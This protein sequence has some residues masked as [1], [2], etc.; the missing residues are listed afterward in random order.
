MANESKHDWSA[1]LRQAL[2]WKEWSTNELSSRSRIAPAR[3]YKYLQ[4]RVA[5][6][7][8]DVVERLARTLGVN[9][10]WLRDGIG[11][12]HSRFPVVGYVGA[13]EAFT[14]FDDLAAGAS[15]DE[16]EFGVDAGDPI[17]VLVRG[18]SMEPVYRP[19]DV[20]ICARR[21]GLDAD[22]FLGRDCVVLLESG[23][24]YVKHV[25]PGRRRGHFNLLSYSAPAIEDVRLEWAAP[26]VWV[27]RRP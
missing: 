17:A 2:A 24:G 10:L 8:G 7:R 22:D 18:R 23:E 16:I 9:E 12:H 1:R 4:G 19:G 25:V 3:L 20:L 26:I 11:P 21:S 5:Q 15:L 27:R 6:P 13:G 14:P